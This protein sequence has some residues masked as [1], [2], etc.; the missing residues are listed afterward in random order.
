MLITPQLYGQSRIPDKGLRHEI[1]STYGSL[2]SWKHSVYDYHYAAEMLLLH[3]TGSVRIGQVVRYTL[4]YTPSADRI[5]PAPQQLHVK[6]KNT[7]AIPLRAA[8]LHG[9]YT[10]YVACY[11]S[12]FDPNKKHGNP[13]QEGAPDFEPNLKAGGQWTSKLSVPQEIR[14]VAGSPTSRQSLDGKAPSFS[15]IIEVVS[16]VIFSTSAAV[17]FELLVGRDERSVELGFYSTAATGQS[18]PGSLE[19]HLQGRTDRSAQH[20]GIFSKAVRLAVDD[21]TT[22]WNSP[23]FP[24]WADEDS[25]GKDMQTKEQVLDDAEDKQQK[26]E[27]PSKKK[28]KIHLVILTHGIH[29]N[30][31]ADMLFLKESIDATAKQARKDARMRRARMKAA[32]VEQKEQLKSEARSMSTTEAAVESTPSLNADESEEDDEDD[33]QVIVRGFGENVVR[34][35]RGIQYLGKRLAK[36]VLSMTYPDQPY[37]PVKSSISK[38]IARS[39]TGQKGT[40]RDGP[41]AHKNSS[42][43]RDEEHINDNLA[44]QITSISFVGHSLGGLTQTYAIAYIKKHSPEFFEKIR[45]VN[46]VAMATPFLGLSN[47]NPIYVRFALDFGLVGRT[48]QDLG[49]TWRPPTMVRSGWGAMI[50]GLGNESQ[51]NKT[52][53]EPGAKPLLRVLPTGPAH[54]ALKLFRNRSVYSNVVNDGIVPLRTSCLL[55]LDWKGLGRVEKAR[56]ENGIVGT[57]VGW[58]WAEMMGQNATSPRAGRPWP[59]IFSDSGEESDGRK[60]GRRTRRDDDVPQPK[61]NAVNEDD[62]STHEVP[63]EPETHQFIK[64][65]PLVDAVHV[66]QQDKQVS[67]QQE[68]TIWSGFLSLFKPQS[69]SKPQSPSPKRTR[70]YRRGQTMG[71]SQDTDSDSPQ[72]SEI[73]NASSR[74]SIRDPSFE[75]NNSTNEN[76]DT[77]PKTTLFESAGDLLKP[78]LPSKEF[79]I[80]PSSRPRTIFHDRV[81]HPEDIPAPAIKKTRSVGKRSFS[82]EGVPRASPNAPADTSLNTSKMNIPIANGDTLDISIEEQIARAYHRDLSWRKVLVRLEPDAHNNMIVRRMLANAYG[83]PVIK[84]MCDTHFGY[85][86]SAITE[87]AMEPNEE[88]VKGTGDQVS[89]SGEQVKGQQDPP[90]IDPGKVKGR[91][92]VAERRTSGSYHSPKDLLNPDLGRLRGPLKRTDSEIR[93]ATDEVA[94]LS[95]TSNNVESSISSGGG[96]ANVPCRMPREDSARWSDR[97]FEGSDDDTDFDCMSSPVAVR[98]GSEDSETPKGTNDADIAK[99]LGRTSPPKT[100]PK[101]LV[102]QRFTSPPRP[103]RIHD[104]ESKTTTLKGD[105][106]ISDPSKSGLS[107]VGLGINLTE[108]TPKERR[109]SIPKQVALATAEQRRNEGG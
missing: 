21:T 98:S 78:P 105:D 82:R 40:G 70:I 104:G 39:L 69:L 32:K 30:V 60:K 59:D 20:R 101:P 11:P 26:Q 8:Y 65:K 90:L 61:E 109:K 24:T 87:D 108:Q 94:D 10:L 1:P 46:F 31:G 95:V 99:F 13:E 96:R 58:G 41:A 17:H 54:A 55:F 83:W 28:Q 56:R 36:Y 71:L 74:P 72:N 25:S 77:P 22:L 29:S 81:Y 91:G 7:S 37:L 64:G 57:M 86:A 97:F 44:Y 107:Q 42:I 100:S 49:L 45:P 88:R 14:E 34:T 79:L 73:N 18:A 93:E 63:I 51:K 80:D 4:T 3:Q 6:I 48:G 92:H 47:E 84:H 27:R 52:E 102:A 67:P 19:D 50:G 68:T 89:R 23:A 106:L 103:L 53:P 15:W 76:M 38:T 5:L 12:T 62:I 35:E 16:Q 2:K 9:P 33:E 85:T 75:S 66:Q 43:C